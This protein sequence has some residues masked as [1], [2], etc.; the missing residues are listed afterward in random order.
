MM[1]VISTRVRA[2]IAKRTQI[3]VYSRFMYYVVQV[4]TGKEEKAIEEILKHN[5][6]ASE[7]DVFAPF[8]KA[9]RKY[10]G[11][12]KEVVERC[13]PGYVFVETDN[14]NQLFIDLYF[15]PGFT[16]LLG[17]ERGTYHFVPLSDEEARMVDIL[18]N[19]NHNRTTPISDIEVVEG[20]KVRV[21]DGPLM[22]MK[23]KIVKVNLHKR[24]A[25]VSFSIGPQ[26]L[27]A[28]LGINIIT[29]VE[30]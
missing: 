12:Y 28:K 8:R 11:V 16:R 26:K 29:R 7:I 4:Q 20:D 22:D 27:E 24:F 25:V 2:S 5:S 23:G 14:P 18:Y 10:S 19:R 3:E 17:R 30:Y 9:M 15:T 6:R 13:F 21:L 1:G